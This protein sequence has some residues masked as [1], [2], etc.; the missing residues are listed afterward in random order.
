MNNDLTQNQ[1]TQPAINSA[2]A[3]PSDCRGLPDGAKTAPENGSSEGTCL[4]DYSNGE[5]RVITPGIRT[6]P[7]NWKLGDAPGDERDVPDFGSLYDYPP[8]AVEVCSTLSHYTD[9]DALRVCL[10]AGAILSPE[11]LWNREHAADRQA[12]WADYVWASFA[13]PWEPTAYFCGTLGG[14][15][16]CDSLGRVKVPTP[17]FEAARIALRPSTALPWESVL[18]GRVK[19]ELTLENFRDTGRCLGAEP[20][21][22][23][24]FTGDV[25]VELW[26]T[27]EIWDGAAWRLVPRS[28]Q[29]YTVADLDA[30]LERNV[31]VGRDRSLVQVVAPIPTGEPT[32]LGETEIPTVTFGAN[33]LGMTDKLFREILASGEFPARSDGGVLR[34]RLAVIG[35]WLREGYNG[36]DK[37][38]RDLVF[39]AKVD[40]EQAA[41]MLGRSYEKVL[42][43]VGR[44]ELP[45][46]RVH[47]GRHCA[48]SQDVNWSVINTRRWRLRRVPWSESSGNG[49]V[50]SRRLE[51][52]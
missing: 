46:I 32:V 11:S 31:F 8:I 15:V 17:P 50:V 14:G 39:G 37:D 9:T 33:L 7:Q 52:T 6:S 30:F 24:I 12:K 3:M 2:E 25:P 44:G 42:E 35:A 41:L 4:P 45:S 27:V 38:N 28:G 20:A 19:T 23:R 51:Y 48:L 29:T 13:A 16:T 5:L 1:G 18:R 22:W 26:L 43:M 49:T 40:L 34:I 47:R 10:Q 21:A 36:T